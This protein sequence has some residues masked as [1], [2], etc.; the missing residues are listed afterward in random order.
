ML[1]VPVNNF[2]VMFGI[3][4]VFLGR[5]NNKQRIKWLDAVPPMSLTSDNSI[6]ILKLEP[7]RSLVYVIITILNKF[8]GVVSYQ[9]NSASNGS[10]R[11]KDFA[12][13]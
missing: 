7:L 5:S 3:C 1:Y 6:S 9:F 12:N 11:D 8:C 13:L 10:G 2:S 4:P